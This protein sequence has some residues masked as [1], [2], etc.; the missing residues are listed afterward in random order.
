MTIHKQ[1]NTSLLSK[2]QCSTKSAL[3]KNFKAKASSRNPKTT[4][5]VFNHPP[6]FGN[7]FNQLGNMAN[8][9]N[10][11]AN[12]SPNPPIPAVNCIA[13]PSEV[14]DPANKEPK[15]GP[16]HEKDTIAR[17]RAMK[18]TP[19]IPPILE[20]ES[21]LSPHELGNVIS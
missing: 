12:A 11:K 4:F 15:I 1:I 6:D 17:V 16:V 8:N 13:P 21:I 7:E 2:P 3:D 14:K 19:M 5:T 18:K 9:A 20:A 10:G